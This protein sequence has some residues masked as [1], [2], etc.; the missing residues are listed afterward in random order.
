[1]RQ[2]YVIVIPLIF[3]FTANISFAQKVKIN[4]NGYNKFLYPTGKISSEGYMKNG[5]PVGI[6]KSYYPNGVLKTIGKRLN[7]QPDSIWKF[8]DEKSN[9]T[10]IINYK[11]NLRSGY[12]Y[13][14]KFVNDSD[15]VKNIVKKKELFVEGKKYGKSFYYTDRANLEKTVMYDE[16]EK[17]GKEI[18]YDTSGK[19]IA[20][21]KYSYGNLIEAEEIN[22]VDKDGNK[23]GVW[24]DFYP[25]GKI[26]MYANYKDNKLNGYYREY[27]SQGRITKSEYYIAGVLKDLNDKN[28]NGGEASD[29]VIEKK[30]TF[31]NGVIKYTGKFVKD[32]PIGIH[33]TFDKK[34]NI[35]KV[36]IYD[37]QGNVKAEGK[38]NKRGRK[39]GEW[40][41]KYKS[42]K[43]RSKGNYKNGRK[44]GN[45]IYFH[46]NNKTEQLGKYVKGRPQGLWKWFF[47]NGKI[48][49]E[50]NFNRGKEDGFFYELAENGDTLSRGKYVRGV[51]EG[52]WK[53]A[54]NDRLEIG[55]YENGKRQGVWKYY[56]LGEKK[57]LQFTGEYK[58]GKPNGKHKYY[59][60]NGKVKMVSFYD[61][62]EKI[63][64]WRKFDT[65]GNIET[66][67]KYRYG[68]LYKID[69]QR[70]SN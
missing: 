41:Y 38:Y 68:E 9:L 49:R 33:K 58:N 4:P 31:D 27:D 1:M 47:D 12:C 42:G 10:E 52:E 21:L 45:W 15:F 16:N 29:E 13:T 3:F 67:Y 63:K 50:G 35:E 11:N 36:V 64:T 59:Y 25:T 37:K 48:R 6:W 54:V 24:K 32:R 22:R 69:G 28:I 44:I 20:I 55:K 17:H 62:G 30:E 26:K 66:T 2:I 56:Y 5:Q 19:I 70:V 39:N 34:G 43:I 40:V 60:P 57:K 8:Y 51:K 61:E 18:Y 53:Y 7:N 65:L 23:F 14:Y 46:E